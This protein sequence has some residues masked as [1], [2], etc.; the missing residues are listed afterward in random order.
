MS[1]YV[2]LAA[3]AVPW[4]NQAYLN[5]SVDETEPFTVVNIERRWALLT[6]KALLKFFKERQQP[7][8][9]ILVDSDVPTEDTRMLYT[10]AGGPATQRQMVILLQGQFAQNNQV[11]TAIILAVG[12]EAMLIN[13]REAVRTSGVNAVLNQPEEIENQATPAMPIQQNRKIGMPEYEAYIASEEN[14]LKLLKMNHHSQITKILSTI[15]SLYPYTI[16][17]L[18]TKATIIYYSGETAEETNPDAPPGLG[19]DA[20]DQGE[21][22]TTLGLFLLGMAY[23]NPSRFPEQITRR[24]RAVAA[25]LGSNPPDRRTVDATI[26]ACNWQTED[27]PVVVDDALGYYI[28]WTVER[29]ANPEAKLSALMSMDDLQTEYHLSPAAIALLDQA[30]LIYLHYHAT[31]INFISQ[32]IP[33]LREGGHTTNAYLAPDLVAY[34]L[35]AERVSTAP[36]LGLRGQLPEAFQIR[37]MSKLVFCALLYYQASLESDEER[38]NFAEYK[39]TDIRNHVQPKEAQSFI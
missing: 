7:L 2:N 15:G 9:V 16:G 14:L 37:T 25:S 24:L 3:E 30:R 35:I 5:Q 6:S 4:I 31:S 33:A 29:R 28:C 20:P 22:L 27:L 1:S 18:S 38:R 21:A 12:H 11:Y 13:V 23:S 19:A 26:Q 34:S 8:L 17:P 10:V 36:F 39:I 32:V